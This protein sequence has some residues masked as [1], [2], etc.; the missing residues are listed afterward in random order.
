MVAR[1]TITNVEIIPSLVPN[2]QVHVEV[3]MKVNHLVQVPAASITEDITYLIVRRGTTF[4]CVVDT[5]YTREYYKKAT[6]A[7][8]HVP[9]ASTFIHNQLIE[10]V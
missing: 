2:M 9:R 7:R 10:K 4:T 3:T 6:Y 5:P 1:M 8:V